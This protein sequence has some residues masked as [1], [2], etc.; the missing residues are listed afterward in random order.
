MQEV[1]GACPFE[2]RRNHR[3][4]QG[5]DEMGS[6]EGHRDETV[7]PNLDRPPRFEVLASSFPEG[8]AHL[9]EC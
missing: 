3:D 1:G 6:G 5:V 4:E 8:G 2:G 7:Y 9:C